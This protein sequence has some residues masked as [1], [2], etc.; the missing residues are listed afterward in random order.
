MLQSYL[1]PRKTV[2][3][4]LGGLAAVMC[5]PSMP[6][7]RRTLCTVSILVLGVLG[8]ARTA[9]AQSQPAVPS[10]LK[11]RLVN[12]NNIGLAN[13]I[14]QWSI[15]GSSP[16]WGITDASGHFAFE[17]PLSVPTQVEVSAIAN[18]YNPAQASVQ[19][20]PGQ[21]TPVNL[22][23]T[24]KSSGQLGTV[25]G[26]VK[27]TSG[28]VIP[29]ARVSI[30][31][32]GGLLTTTTNKSGNYQLNNVGFNSN[33]ILQASTA[34]PPCIA[35]TE[36]LLSVEATEVTAN[37]QAQGVRTIE[38]NCPPPKTS[39]VGAVE[40]GVPAPSIDD[41]VQWEQADGLSITSPD[42]ANAWNAGRVN[43]ILRF[44]SQGGL[45]EG[46]LVASDE[47]GVWWLL[48][49]PDIA[50]PLSNKW[51]SV[52]MSSLALGT[53]GPHDVYAGTYPY[54][55]SEGGDLWESD[56]S[57]SE[58]LN[59]WATVS[60]KPPCGSINKVLVISEFNFIVLACDSGLYWSQIPAP[61]S[62]HGTYNWQ[63]VLP[64]TVAGHAF[65]GL[66]KGPGWSVTGTIGTIVASRWGTPATNQMIYTATLNAGNLVLTP[67]G[68]GGT[69]QMY[70]RTSVAACAS[71][72][73]IMY[74][75]GSVNGSLGGLFR[76][77]DGGANWKHLN[78]PTNP[79]TLGESDQ[80][81]AVSPDCSTVA[82]GWET[83]TF[84]SSN[85]GAS[86]TML[87]DSGEYNNLHTD[88]TALTFDAA[89]A[90]NLFIGSAG[91]VA[92]SIGVNKFV[93]DSEWNK[94]LFNLEFFQASP[95]DSATGLVAGAA[96]DNGVI[97]S[98]LPGE[99]QHV[100]DC[101]LSLECW[102]DVTGFAPFDRLIAENVPTKGS[103]WGAEQ[104]QAVNGV[105]PFNAAAAIP[106]KLS[107][108][109]CTPYTMN[110]VVPVRDPGYFDNGV[111]KIVGGVNDCELMYAVSE[112]TV[113]GAGGDGLYGLFA[114]AGDETDIHWERL[115]SGAL[116]WSQVTAIAP[117]YDGEHI[118]IG[119]TNGQI[120][121]LDYPFNG[122]ATQLTVN[123]KCAACPVNGLYAF[124]FD[125]GAPQL[126]QPGL[127]YAAYGPHFLA[128]DGVS[129]SEMGQTDLP[130]NHDFLSILA[131]DPSRIY[132]ASS[133]GVFDSKTGGAT[134]SKASV[135]LPTF[136]AGVPGF[137]QSS[138]AS[139]D[140]LQIVAD[141][142]PN[143]D[144]R[145]YLASF[146]RS[147]WRTFTAMPSP[148]AA[149]AFSTVDITIQTGN[150]NLADYSELQAWIF[151]PHAT[152]QFICLKPSTTSDASYNN[153]CPN[154]PG[155]TD[156]D[157]NQTWN[158]GQIVSQTFS[159][160]VPV[161]LDQGSIQIIL[162]QHNSGTNTPD[163]WDLQAIEIDGQDTQGILPVLM[164]SNG[165]VSGNNCMARLKAPP[166]TA[167]VLYSLSGD[168]PEG[169]NISHSISTFGV[170]PPGGCPQ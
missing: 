130:H 44:P 48:T 160:G 114:F 95:S 94:E 89:P 115:N 24:L 33:L 155:A 104:V 75:V 143:P 145:L 79:G 161:V 140:Y 148:P 164:M 90:D 78:R 20:Q 169:I 17:I 144:T 41:T 131:T 42:A 22:S 2:R 150:D 60:P 124:T 81:I 118:F 49:D 8:L 168:D 16:I 86:W 66:A 23:L 9:C 103:T 3:T 7:T 38:P 128:Y 29:N 156:R 11:G 96:Q 167:L 170:T 102:G 25:T 14:V 126:Q 84:V 162:F 67:S 121:R 64:A 158:N 116:L 154:G 147:V 88:V 52:T 132:L 40:A 125:P 80:A 109:P 68:V 63:Q 163:N 32:A 61:P 47:G 135:G 151:P 138:L 119:N 45:D 137:R 73:K 122:A 152:A 112:M 39:R 99:W 43:D 57:Q 111:C 53:G 12:A 65:S 85:Q 113:P 101:P 59:S 35:T 4:S 36:I 30:L 117:T 71:N 127:A 139:H 62:V 31:G 70:N 108:T 77:T 58:P 82:L 51:T 50:T 15:V 91:G 54:G 120:Y 133:A 56:T 142:P 129:W 37:L 10:V 34:S 18:L 97:Y 6:R 146:G 141:P 55:D 110:V 93:Y 19:L 157:G 134:W 98:V 107:C 76:S 106:V 5:T 105:I 153:T 26:I 21:I 83:G 1:R 166:F 136:I 27:N 123:L 28:A 69:S 72:P 74:A 46:L 165:A 100:M 13:A 92:E 87:T 159:L 149:R